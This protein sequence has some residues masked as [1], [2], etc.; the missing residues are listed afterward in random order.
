DSVTNIEA[1]SKTNTTLALRG[2]S[3]DATN[4]TFSNYKYDFAFGS[5]LGEIE[6]VTI[7]DSKL[8]GTIDLSTN[9]NTGHKIVMR[10]DSIE[11][12]EAE[13]KFSTTT[14]NFGASGR[15]VF[16]YDDY[17]A[18]RSASSTAP[19]LKLSGLSQTNYLTT[20]SGLDI[21]KTNFEGNIWADN[22]VNVKLDFRDGRTWKMNESGIDLKLGSSIVIHGKIE[23]LSS[24]Q[25]QQISQQNTGNTAPVPKLSL[26]INEKQGDIQ[27]I[28]TGAELYWNS[29]YGYANESLAKSLDLRGTSL[30]KVTYSTYGI[31]GL[32]GTLDGNRVMTMTFASGSNVDTIIKKTSSGN[33]YAK[34][35]DKEAD[36]GYLN[37]T[38]LTHKG[39]YSDGIY[40]GNYIADSY[41]QFQRLVTNSA[42][43]IT[44][45]GDK[46]KRQGNGGNWSNN[47]GFLYGNGSK[48]TLVNVKDNTET[49]SAT[50]STLYANQIGGF[51]GKENLSSTITVTLQGTSIQS[52]GNLLKA[53][54]Q[55][56]KQQGRVTFDMTFVNDG[57]TRNTGNT[58]VDTSKYG[59]DL[60]LTN[61]NGALSESVLKVAESSLE[62][63]VDF[64]DANFNVLFVGDASQS[65]DGNGSNSTAKIFKG[66]STT[67]KV[68]FRDSNLNAG[69]GTSSIQNIKGTIAFDLS[70]N[71]ED[72]SI[73]GTLSNM[74]GN[75]SN[76]YNGTGKYQTKFGDARGDQADNLVIDKL[77][78]VNLSQANSSNTLK[79]LQTEGNYFNDTDTFGNLSQADYSK[80]GYIK[81]LDTT[82]NSS[83][84]L[85][86][87]S[88]VALNGANQEI[89]FIGADS[90]GFDESSTAKISATKL[91]DSTGSTLT[92]IDAGTLKVDNLINKDTSGNQ[93]GKGTINLIG[94]TRIELKD[95]STGVG[96]R[97][98]AKT[99]TL[100]SANSSTTGSSPSTIASPASS[101]TAITGAGI[102]INAVFTGSNVLGDGVA[103]KDQNGSNNASDISSNVA[104]NTNIGQAGEQTTYHILFDYTDTLKDKQN[105]GFGNYQVYQGT[106]T[107]LTSESIIKFKN[108]G[109]INQTQ[110][111]NTK[112]TILLDN[113][114]LKGDFRGDVA[115]LDFRNN[116]PAISGNILTS[117]VRSTTGGSPST[118]VLSRKTL[119]FDLTGGKKLSG[120]NGTI[121]AGYK[122]APDYSTTGQSI[123]TFQNAPTMTLGDDSGSKLRGGA[124][125]TNPSAFIQSLAKDVGFTG[126]ANAITTEP[127]SQ[128]QAPAVPSSPA[129]TIAL[130]AAPTI[131]NNTSYILK[132]TKL[133]FQGTSITANGSDKAI[134]ENTYELDLSFDMSDNRGST[135]LGE[136]LGKSTLTANS[137]TMGSYDSNGDKPLGL[138]LS[139][140][141]AGSL[142]GET[143]GGV[144]NVLSVNLARNARFNLNAESSNGNIGT[145]VFNE[146]KQ[147]RGASLPPF[148]APALEVST[149]SS[150]NISAGSLGFVGDFVQA[151]NTPANSTA[152]TIN[153]A[154]DGTNKVCGTLAGRGEM[155]ISLKGDALFSKEVAQT[156]GYGG[157]VQEANLLID[158]SN[159]TSSN[160]TL[161]HSSGGVEVKGK[162]YVSSGTQ[163][164]FTNLNLNNYTSNSSNSL[165]LQ[166]A[167]DLG[168]ANLNFTGEQFK[169]T[170]N[171]FF[172]VNSGSS[173]TLKDIKVAQNTTANQQDRQASS[174]TTKTLSIGAI[175]GTT[176]FALNLTLTNLDPNLIVELTNTSRSASIQDWGNS[177]I[178]NIRGTNIQL[179][180]A[181]WAE[182]NT[183]LKKFVFAK[184]NGTEVTK[185]PASQ[186]QTQ[187]ASPLTLDKLTGD[188]KINQSAL[189]GSVTTA[190][191]GDSNDSQNVRNVIMKNGEMTFIGKQSLAISEA[192]QKFDGTQGKITFGLYNTILKS[193]SVLLDNT[194]NG[195]HSNLGKNANI[196]DVATLRGTDTFNLSLAKSSTADSG[197]GLNN[198][199]IDAVF[200]NGSNLVATSTPTPTVSTAPTILT[201][202]TYI[203]AS[204]GANEALKTTLAQYAT[205]NAGG[206]L[207]DSILKTLQS[208]AY[209]NITLQSETKDSNHQV[210]A[211]TGVTANMKFI[212]ENSHSFDGKT[213]VKGSGT[214][215]EVYQYTKADGNLSTPST[216]ANEWNKIS[217]D[218][219]G[220]V[221]LGSRPDSNPQIG[222]DYKYAQLI[223]G[224][225]NSRFD[226]DHTT[227]AL[228]LVKFA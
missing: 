178:W 215:A 220:I 64:K 152:G 228:D 20:G 128:A 134:S 72:M 181:F 33:D 187:D 164:N 118:N 190:T 120:F 145:I 198:S 138:S 226:F 69:N 139:F 63:G 46:S 102:T 47:S 185:D 213:I 28:N 219:K 34:I 113:T 218:D 74:F 135:G 55:D 116:R 170:D 85:A 217:I 16:V 142:V 195:D 84:T 65:L 221:S 38:Q 49:N 52:G 101:S 96:A 196:Q 5:G 192:N 191:G 127:T 171:L 15:G 193:G 45:I 143:K 26:R 23:K 79:T 71:D 124:S 199:T 194:N 76:G 12:T 162:A 131:D 56:V 159:A 140:K 91:G 214:S 8:K 174:P 147:T 51:I 86:G 59:E 154:F 92:F 43:N 182:N 62:D 44:F 105:K 54:G 148:G 206:A 22:S 179:T 167:F 132:G 201:G 119:T 211:N 61:A 186:T 6:G 104:S 141:D 32:H 222:S 4:I 144:D 89:V 115:I 180:T 121:Q 88:T 40:D 188:D 37:G 165:T 17:T 172:K 150:L 83:L 130:A 66:G 19:T 125:Q 25:N 156:L 197:R 166:G 122:I 126:I 208:K 31:N 11:G 107:G 153:V 70:H 50:Q 60:G 103:V 82:Q 163:S 13:I 42:V 225:A 224:N 209:G 41:G 117:D 57:D 58:Y 9:T 207:S 7:Q 161:A 216:Q 109:Y 137:I 48:L 184:G 136:T 80:F 18:T 168:N 123:L 99:L 53:N 158:A 200:V 24:Q 151:N 133:V 212:G 87:N 2:T 78:F 110:I 183:N 204:K 73:S 95:I 97:N 149:D 39:G 106:I 169:V 175:G 202:N 93:T 160:I 75:G 146:I 67:S 177:G 30:A 94:S 227:V 112:A 77:V 223:G 114:Q 157:R 98:T 108:A 36:T 189:S 10:G 81:D 27:L 68:T 100:Y 21:S 129:G 35:T 90:H 29:D 210:V 173:I 1:F 111:Q 14:A 205:T 155:N 3:L 203:D 176:K